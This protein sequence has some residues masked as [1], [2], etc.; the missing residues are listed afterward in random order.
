MP[1]TYAI[2][3]GRT[4]M[5]A[6]LYTGTNATQSITNT[7]NGVFMQPDL[8]WMKARSSALSNTLTDAVR[9]VSTQL[10]SNLTNAETT[11]AGK[12]LTAFNSNGFTLGPDLVGTGSVNANTV[13]YVGWQWNAG[14]STVTNTSGT[15]SAQVRANTTAGFSVVT[16]TGNGVTAATVGHGLTAIPA[17]VIIKERGTAG[18]NWMVK[19]QS[20]ASSNN[21]FLQGPNATTNITSAVS[22]GGIA[23][24][25]SS[26]TFNFLAGTVNTDNV[27][28]NT[29]TFV[30]YCFAQ[31]AGY[32]AFGSYAGNSS[33]DG[34]FVYLG[35]RPRWLMIKNISIGTAAQSD[36][37]IVDTSR[38]PS[39]VGAVYLLANTAAAQ[40]TTGGNEYI[41]ILSNGF[42]LRGS[43]NYTNGP[44]SYIYAAF[45]ENPFKY[46]NAR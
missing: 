28:R 27:N 33:S 30:A 24:L 41:D 17:M 18:T 43:S 37:F 4:V 11:E 1:T 35:F 15:I 42:K 3:D 25:S 16:Y 44:Y 12:G 7:V 38:S 32:S 26:T 10:F 31:V 21:L 13:T 5:A 46:A 2:P 29:G 40:V 39:N 6:T 23:N 9:G 8:V 34:V 36:W 20:L 22:G 45:A 19:H 14:G